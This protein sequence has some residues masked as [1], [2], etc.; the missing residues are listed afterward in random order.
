M[1]GC[2]LLIREVR[3]NVLLKAVP[4][5][6]ALTLSGTP[7]HAKCVKAVNTVV[8]I[9]EME[10]ASLIPMTTARAVF[11]WYTNKH[12]TVTIPVVYLHFELYIIIRNVT[13][14]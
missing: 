7:A 5:S 9:V 4:A 11:A 6:P 10:N 1:A 13:K 8:G 2:F 14:L 12:H 3:F